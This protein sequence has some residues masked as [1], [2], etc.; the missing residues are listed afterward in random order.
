DG[1]KQLA[2][3]MKDLGKVLIVAPGVQRSGESK[4]LTLKRPL[5]PTKVHRFDFPAYSLD[6]TPADSV[7][8]GRYLARKEY[9]KT[10]D[11]VVSGINSGDNTSV[12]ALL[13][14][15]TVAA[16]FESSLIGIP[17]IAFSMEVPTSELFSGGSNSD[18]TSSAKRSKEIAKLVLSKPLPKEVR[19]LNVNFPA[20]TNENTPVEIASL[21]P[22]KYTNEII[23]DKDPR[24]ADIYW[25]WGGN[26]K[27]LDE[28]TDAYVVY[29]K[30]SISITPITLGFGRWS[31]SVL[32]D[33]YSSS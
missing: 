10:P 6:G 12:H 24:N 7:I 14:S 20:S 25:I 31:V 1:I 19:F 16:S 3:E 30:K 32:K 17:S 33:W 28:G 8:M 11:L 26:V 22:E 9:G 23:E 5:R 21:S 18:Y 15:G 2:N 27:E 4:S 13:T 29:R